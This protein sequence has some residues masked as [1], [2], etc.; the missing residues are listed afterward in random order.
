MTCYLDYNGTTIMPERVI[1][2]LTKWATRGN[3]S[4]IYPSAKA[5]KRMMECLKNDIARVNNFSLDDMSIIF[6]SGGSEAN[7][8]II[9]GAIRSF[10]R[11]TGKRPHIIISNI[12]HD[13]IMLMAKALEDEDVDVTRIPVMTEGPMLGSVNPEDVYNAIRPNTCIIAIMS[14]N[15]ETGIRNNIKAIGYV[16]KNKG[17]PF[18]TDAVQ[19]FGKESINPKENHIT[20][21]TG[22]FH[23]LHGP[24][25][26]GV[27]VVSNSFLKGYDIKALIPGHQNN[28]L[29]GGTECVHNI[30]ASREAYNM[31]FE[32]REQKNK[33]MYK[34]KN[35]LLN[36]LQ[37]ILPI[38]YLEDYRNNK[39]KLKLPFIVH[40]TPVDNE[41]NVLPNTVFISLYF[42]K[43]CNAK[44][45][46]Q[47][48]EKDIFISVGSVCKTGQS[49]SSHVLDGLNVP[50][51]LVPGVIRISLGDFTTK[52]DI[53]RFIS[54]LYN[55]LKEGK[56][57][58]S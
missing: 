2:V 57:F 17:V 34:L 36:G 55:I 37:K 53:D 16:A 26:C 30:A 39:N 44:V 13:N 42:D 49:K 9:T 23:K 1:N 12:E 6:T 14:A 21:F 25:G 7:T 8:F 43:I 33:N 15:N 46:E 52:N 11:V 51:E 48:A 22:S 24:T 29:R 28:G 32:D 4:S 35:Y 27:A 50:K 5:A 40:L 20:A 45:R 18:M 54:S 38:Y 10:M 47:L 56:C 3:A 31:T 19:V 58:K 41:A